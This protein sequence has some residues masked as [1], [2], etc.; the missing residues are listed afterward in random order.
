[1]P[2]ICDHR[3]TRIWTLIGVVPSLRRLTVDAAP[4]AATSISTG[5][6]CS[7]AARSDIGPA[8]KT[9]AAKRHFT[10]D[11]DIIAPQRSI[12]SQD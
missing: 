3:K 2:S 7:V 4:G 6:I 11:D 12:R 5:S 10:I 1:L 8:N 9:A